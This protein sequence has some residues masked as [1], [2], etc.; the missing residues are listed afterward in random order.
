LRAHEQLEAEALFE[1]LDVPSDGR[2]RK[3]EQ[4]RGAGQRSFLQD[5]EEAAVEAPVGLT[6]IHIFSYSISKDFGNFI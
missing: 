4:A 3:P 6:G 5:G 1:R 2:L